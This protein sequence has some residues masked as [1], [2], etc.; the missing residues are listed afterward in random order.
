MEKII[1]AGAE[2][3]DVTERLARA[4]AMLGEPHAARRVAEK[5]LALGKHRDY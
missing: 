5:I 3:D 4:V 1:A 2:R